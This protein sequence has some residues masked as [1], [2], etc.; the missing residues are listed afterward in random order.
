MDRKLLDLV[1]ENLEPIIYNESSYIFREGEPV[2][3]MFF[4]TKGIAMT[5]TTKNGG[6]RTIQLEKEK[7]YLYGEELLSWAAVPS[8]KLSNVPLSTITVKSVGK[9]EVFALNAAE[10]QDVVSGFPSYFNT[11]D[12]CTLTEIVV[13]NNSSDISAIRA[14]SDISVRLPRWRNVSKRAQGYESC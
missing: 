12:I 1:C 13:D 8:R 9:V 4:I 6:S 11:A 5:Y 3:K 7:D 14:S 10:F 2:D